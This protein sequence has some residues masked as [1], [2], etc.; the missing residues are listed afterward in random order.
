MTIIKGKHSIEEALKANIPV[1]AI[2]VAQSAKADVSHILKIASVKKIRV[3]TLQAREFRNRYKLHD[4]QH[5]IAEVYPPKQTDLKSILAEPEKYPS[6]VVL[7]HLEDPY[8]VGAIARTCEGMG[9]TTIVYAKNRQASLTSGVIKASSG[10]IY[11]LNCVEVANIAT[12]VDQL[13]QKGYWIY[14]ADSNQ[15]TSLV[16]APK[17]FPLVVV[18]GNEHNGISKRV[19]SFLDC[20]ILIPM[21]G[22]VDSFNVSVATGIILFSLLN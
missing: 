20:K 14:G 13:K 4:A 7:D 6:I 5:I 9:I 21:K 19:S 1:K 10:A 17:N 3:T 2:V 22:Y 18:V 8:N 11:H 16:E 12:A 15:G